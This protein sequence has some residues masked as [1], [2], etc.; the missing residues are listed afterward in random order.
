MCRGGTAHF[1]LQWGPLVCRWSEGLHWVLR[2]VANLVQF[3]DHHLQRYAWILQVYN[4]EHLSKFWIC[5]I[6]KQSPCILQPLCPNCRTQLIHQVFSTSSGYVG[7]FNVPVQLLRLPASKGTFS[8][9]GTTE[10]PPA[11]TMAL[12]LPHYDGNSLMPKA[13]L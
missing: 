2:E 7:T 13:G 1:R 10:L 12:L 11:I 4:L 6:Q 5:S 3:L 9:K 8:S